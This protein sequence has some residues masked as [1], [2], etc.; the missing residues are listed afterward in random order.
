MSFGLR[1][2]LSSLQRLVNH[3]ISG[4]EGRAVYLDDLVVFSDSRES[5]LRHLRTVLQ[6][7]SDARLTVNLEK[8]EFAKANVTCHGKVVGNGKVCPVQEKIQAIQDFPPSDEKKKELM[9]FLGLV[10]YYRSFVVISP[11]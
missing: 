6:R 11:Q 7:L 3:V 4:L 1:N 5:H 10:G 8:C 9:R 2:A